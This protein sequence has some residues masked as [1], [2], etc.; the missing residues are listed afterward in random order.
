MRAFHE[1][2]D[3]KPLLLADPDV[4]AVLSPE[5]IER[6]FDLDEQFRHVD[7]IFTRVF[8]SEGTR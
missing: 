4:T 8:G 6:S 7:D 1:K 2:R 3:F 5:E